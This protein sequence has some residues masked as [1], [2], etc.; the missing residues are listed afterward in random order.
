MFEHLSKPV[1]TLFINLSQNSASIF[2]PEEEET[3]EVL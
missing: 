2:K 3:Y 1:V